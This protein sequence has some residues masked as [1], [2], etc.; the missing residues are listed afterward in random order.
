MTGKSSDRR[1]VRFTEDQFRT[2]MAR[3]QDLDQRWANGLSEDDV[4]DIAG[5]LG[6]SARA[7][8]RALEES[9]S[10]TRRSA[11]PKGARAGL[12]TIGRNA[13]PNA[14]IGVLLGLA[15]GLSV[16]FGLPGEA[17]AA[18]LVGA[19]TVAGAA[20]LVADGDRKRSDFQLSNAGLWCAFGAGIYVTLSSGPSWDELILMT[21]VWGT[22]SA[23]GGELL[24]R[25]RE[26]WRRSPDLLTPI[27]SMVRRIIPRPQLGKEG[28]ERDMA[29]PLRIGVDPMAGGPLPAGS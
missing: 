1:D 18:I 20:A 11:Q 2:I 22:T 15:A 5:E 17:S 25:L 8:S 9:R 3:A 23:V 19:Y 26:W 27:A 10:P 6:I 29:T 12:R 4:R 16:A 7:I 14:L 13:A 21:W 24:M 28:V